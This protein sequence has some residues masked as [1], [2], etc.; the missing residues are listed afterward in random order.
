M[1]T[2]NSKIRSAITRRA[3][4]AAQSGVGA[5]QA[6]E[7]AGA[8]QDAAPPVDAGVEQ[9]P[10]SPSPSDDSQPAVVPA[11]TA[12][13]NPGLVDLP[14]VP[15][16]ERQ[17]ISKWPTSDSYKIWAGDMEFPP[18]WLQALEWVELEEDGPKLVFPSS[19][20]LDTR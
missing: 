11:I 15:I 19:S 13:A 16:K 6:A 2:I 1:G 10:A 18:T 9:T 8:P 12:V 3:G 14:G 4:N 17:S 20:S 7:P 5:T